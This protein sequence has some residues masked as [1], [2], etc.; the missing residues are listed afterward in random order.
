MRQF[1]AR[2]IL[3]P[4]LAALGM[5]LSCDQ[6]ASQ[7]NV[8]GIG[9]GTQIK[10]RLISKGQSPKLELN[11]SAPHEIRLLKGNGVLRSFGTESLHKDH[12]DLGVITHGLSLSS[13]EQ[14]VLEGSIYLCQ[15]DDLKICRKQKFTQRM[16]FAST[17]AMPGEL[18]VDWYF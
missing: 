10:I 17:I 16:T 11:S 15:K 9:R 8:V 4:A 7:P 6:E 13:N 1:W 3:V 5:C 18:A 2:W 14:L 12:F